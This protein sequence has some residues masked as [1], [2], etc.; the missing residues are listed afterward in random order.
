MLQVFCENWAAHGSGLQTSFRIDHHRFLILA[1]DEQSGGASGCSIDS[2]VRVVKDLGARLGIDF[3]NRA[4][5]AFWQEGEVK[6]Y[7]LTQLKNLFANDTLN[8]QTQAFNTL[9]V[10]WGE[11]NI[12]YPKYQLKFL[13]IP[14]TLS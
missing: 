11:W 7:P 13:F 12:T 8:P 14:D 4:D 1:V 9:A 10:T 2:S 6:T 5:V 3:F